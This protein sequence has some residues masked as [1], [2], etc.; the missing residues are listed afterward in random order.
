MNTT[1]AA[2]T[3]TFA[4]VQAAHEAGLITAEQA[5]SILGIPSINRLAEVS[6]ALFTD[7]V[8][9]AGNWSGTP[10]VDIS[11]EERGNL[12]QLKRAKLLSTQTDDGIAFAYFTPEGVAYAKALG[13]GEYLE[14]LY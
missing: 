9:D 11:K 6:V 8:K 7:L 5:A 3:G 12:T 13:L 1:A 4:Q 14:G 10:M 2:T